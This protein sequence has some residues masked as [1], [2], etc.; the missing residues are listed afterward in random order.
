MVL[1]TAVVFL[2][3]RKINC[4]ENCYNDF[5]LGIW[6]VV[7]F[8]YYGDYVHL[9]VSTLHY[10]HK[11][12][13]LCEGDCDRNSDCEGTLVCHQRTHNGDGPNEC[14]GWQSFDAKTDFCVYGGYGNGAGDDDD[15]ALNGD[16]DGDDEGDGDDL[17]GDILNAE[18][19]TENYDFE[20]LPLTF[21][22]EEGSDPNG[23]MPLGLCQGDC[24]TDS[25]CLGKEYQNM[26]SVWMF[27]VI[28][29]N[30]SC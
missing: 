13:G 23:R 9:I 5:F 10:P 19:A 8:V 29:H 21:K 6:S 25:D 20:L 18:V 7:F 15:R 14:S 28:N 17:D 4:V 27:Y 12:T 24:D 22:Q 16:D 3:V 11:Q 2:W 1:L 26:H 30:Y